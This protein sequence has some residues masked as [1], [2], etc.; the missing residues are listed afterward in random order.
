MVAGNSLLRSYNDTLEQRA[1]SYA[2][3]PHDGSSGGPT[4][5][6]LPN[7][8]CLGDLR[9]QVAFPM[10]WDGVNLDSPDHHSHMAYPTLV[11]NGRCPESHPKR[12]LYLFYETSWLVSDFDDMWHG[13]QQPFVVANG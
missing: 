8:K 3:I 11:D 6:G 12:L 1:I 7:H 9:I 13:D 4:T 2:C 5:P 10:C